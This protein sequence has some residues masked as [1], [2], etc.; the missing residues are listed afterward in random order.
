MNSGIKSIFYVALLVLI[1]SSCS[2]NETEHINPHSVSLSKVDSVVLSYSEPL[3]GKFVEQFRINDEGDIWIFSERNQN[4]IF[5]FDSLGQ[6]INVVGERGKGPKGIMHVSGFEINRENQVIINDAAQRMLKIFD[7]SGELIHSNTVFSEGELWAHP[8]AMYNFKDRLLISVTESEFIR[9][10]HKSKLL[11]IV[12]YEGKVDT[13]FGKHDKFTTEDNSYS[14]ENTALIDSNFIYTSSVGSPHIQ[15]FSKD[16]FQ[17]IDYFG[18]NTENFSIPEKEVHANLPISEIKKRSSGSSVIAGI[19]GTDQFI[20]LHMQNLTEEFFKTTD[21]TKK[22]N[23]LILYNRD[24]K[25]F[26][27][28]IPVPYTLAAVHH[29]KLY[30]IE[31]FNADNYTIGIYKFTNEK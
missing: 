2:T 3:F 9:E 28:E 1:L 27:K 31:D 21:F 5:A 14:A 13:V 10:P 15:M 26:I 18:E 19:Y 16:T 17:Q 30:L 25:E 29:N 22:N 23:I 8:Y 6:F 20:V 24:T 7:L 11:A 12:D 4:R